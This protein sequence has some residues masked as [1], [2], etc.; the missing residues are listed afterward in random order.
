MAEVLL[1]IV[2][3]EVAIHR[4][5]NFDLP[6]S[7]WDTHLHPQPHWTP[8]KETGCTHQAQ[9]SPHWRPG[10]DIWCQ[11]REKWRAE[12]LDY[13]SS[14]WVALS[15]LC[16]LFILDM[17]SIQLLSLL[18]CAVQFLVSVCHA[19]WCK[20]NRKNIVWFFISCKKIDQLQTVLQPCST[21]W[22]FQNLPVSLS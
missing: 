22:C 13:A 6:D 3:F 19:Q 14:F 2:Y 16:S 10:R 4:K 15:W 8:G 20:N 17:L 12:Q 18:H 7:A 1:D 21:K 11:K 5:P 9:S